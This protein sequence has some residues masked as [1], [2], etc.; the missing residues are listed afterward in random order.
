MESLAAP[1]PE[2][3]EALKAALAS[4]QAEL[5]AAK[6]REANKQ[7]KKLG[8]SVDDDGNFADDDLKAAPDPRKTF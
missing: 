5:D 6:K 2:D 3:V 4:M 8:G 1:V 7:A